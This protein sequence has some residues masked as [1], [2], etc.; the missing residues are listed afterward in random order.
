MCVH[1]IEK[2]NPLVFYLVHEKQQPY[3]IVQTNNSVT[4]KLIIVFFMGIFI[5]SIFRVKI[6][7]KVNR[8]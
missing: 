7:K 1:L 2:V 5:G 4:G 3:H 6:W 8:Q